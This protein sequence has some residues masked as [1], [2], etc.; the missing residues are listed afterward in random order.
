MKRS[1]ETLRG[2]GVSLA[3]H[4]LLLILLFFSNLPVVMQ[5]QEFVEIS[6][7]AAMAETS[8]PA[9]PAPSQAYIPQ[10]KLEAKSA[11]RQQPSSAVQLPE[12]RLPDLSEEVFSIPRTEKQDAVERPFSTAPREA[13]VSSLERATDRSARDAGEREKSTPGSSR[14]VTAEGTGGT[15]PGGLGSGVDQGVT[16]SIQ[17]LEGGTRRKIGG[18]LPQYPEGVNVEAQIKIQAVVMP[19]GAVKVIQPLQKGNTKLEEAA[20]KEL[21]FWRFEPLRSSQPKLEQPC[22]VIFL[23][24]LK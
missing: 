15:A 13:V 20:M 21:R 6:W 14:G 2:W 7:G 5:S 16:F 24:K 11:V 23:F 3:I 1:N 22:V 17:W 10:P 18:D 4:L 19:D 12:R 8:S 9:A